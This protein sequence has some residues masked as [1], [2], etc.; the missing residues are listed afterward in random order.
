MRF[1]QNGRRIKD[2]A[3]TLGRA[4]SAATKFDSDGIQ[5]RFMNPESV[6]IP[7]AQLNNLRHPQDVDRL[8]GKDGQ[9]GIVRFSGI[10]PLGTRLKSEVIDPLIMKDLE[11]RRLPKPV[12]VIIITDGEPQGE[13]PKALQATIQATIK[14]AERSYGTGARPVAFQVAQVGND[15]RAMA[16]LGDL[17]KDPVVGSFVDCTSSKSTPNS[18]LL[19][20]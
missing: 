1:E 3:Q 11:H 2:L 9:G 6:S 17:D 15:E 12:L 5:L 19:H 7:Q 16:F 18:V 10:T 4:A 13:S 14:S 20:D 8:I